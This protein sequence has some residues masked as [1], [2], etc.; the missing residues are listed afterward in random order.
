MG[1]VCETK[2]RVLDR[3]MGDNS[4]ASSSTLASKSKSAE[5]TSHQ[6]V[7]FFNDRSVDLCS[8]CGSKYVYGF[9]CQC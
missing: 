9:T 4:S 3:E 6:V 5:V 1:L 8:S 7:M 2:I